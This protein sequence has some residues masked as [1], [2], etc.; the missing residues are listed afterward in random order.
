MAFFT[1]KVV[2]F[3]A[4]EDRKIRIVLIW[5]WIQLESQ[6]DNHKSQYEKLQQYES[7]SSQLLSGSSVTSFNYN[8]TNYN[9]REALILREII[10]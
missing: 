6:L 1:E 7:N 10:N 2:Q 9:Y 5:K 3:N 4:K 8:R